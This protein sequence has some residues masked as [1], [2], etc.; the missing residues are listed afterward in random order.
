[1]PMSM[2]IAVPAS[3]PAGAVVLKA[4]ASPALPRFCLAT[5]V[6]FRYATN[7]SSKSMLRISRWTQARLAT[8]NVFRAK[9][10]M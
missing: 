1:M 4:V 9:N 6:P 2:G 10:A 3:L 7:P 5:S 8:E